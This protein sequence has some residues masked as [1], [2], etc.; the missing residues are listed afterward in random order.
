MKIISIYICYCCKK[1]NNE[2]IKIILEFAAFSVLEEI[3]YTR[4]NGQYL[5]WDSR[6][7]RSYGNTEF[8]KGEIFDFITIVKEK[9]K[10]IINGIFHQQ[11]VLNFSMKRKKIKIF[12]IL[13]Y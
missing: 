11:K 2:S 7:N 12:L 1:I 6:A 10:E 9:I 5:R 4:K 13:K 3:S 8:N